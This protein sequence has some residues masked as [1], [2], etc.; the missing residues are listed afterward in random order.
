MHL[1]HKHSLHL[2]RTGGQ[3]FALPTF[4]QVPLPGCGPAE[5]SWGVQQESHGAV[6]GQGHTGSPSSCLGEKRGMGLE[7]ASKS[8]VLVLLLIGDLLVAQTIA[9]WREDQFRHLHGADAAAP[10]QPPG[11]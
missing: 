5:G 4:Q 7:E 2:T 8:A 11:C 6:R 10:G 9:S 3:P 1:Q